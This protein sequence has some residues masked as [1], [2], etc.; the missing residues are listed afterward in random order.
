MPV[1]TGRSSSLSPL[2]MRDLESEVDSHRAFIG[3]QAHFLL[4]GD[5]D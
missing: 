3:D 4:V 2:D 5:D 1:K